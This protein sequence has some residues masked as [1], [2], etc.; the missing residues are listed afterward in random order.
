MVLTPQEKLKII[1]KHSKHE[2]DTGSA[3]VQIAIFTAEIK[4]LTTHL[5]KHPKDN[6]SRTGILKMVSKRK[7]LLGYLK[8]TSPRA[9]N[10]VIKDLGL[11][12]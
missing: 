10:S 8:E 4:R 1:Q 12:R 3:P 7:R 11:K 2:G 9:Y 5:K 6:H